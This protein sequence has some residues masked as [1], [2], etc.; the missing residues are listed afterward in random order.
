MPQSA[1]VQADAPDFQTL[2]KLWL[3]GYLPVF[4]KHGFEPSA[5]GSLRIFLRGKCHML[6][7]CPV[8][9]CGALGE[10]VVMHEW[11]PDMTSEKAQTL[12]ENS[13]KM[14]WTEI[15]ATHQPKVLIFPAGLWAIPTYFDF[16][17]HI[18][19]FC[20]IRFCRLGNFL[21]Q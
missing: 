6:A 2:Q 17:R 9:F 20:S 13:V 8:R 4:I 5:A 14:W 1:K 21:F 16:L 10:D 15:D 18:D 19:T 3:F 7:M 11:I 12:K